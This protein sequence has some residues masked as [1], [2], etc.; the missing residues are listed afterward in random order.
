[1]LDQVHADLQK[2]PNDPNAYTFG[3]IGKHN[4]VIACLPKGKIGTNSAATITTWMVST[5]PSIKFG[6]MVGIGGGIPPKVRLGD[7][8]VSIPVGQFSGVVQWDFGKAKEG[9]FERTGS[10]NNPPNLLL[11]AL[12]K[13]ETKH[14]LTGSKIPEYLKELKEKWPRLIPKYLKSDSLED[15]LCK[16]DYSHIN[17]SRNYG[18]ISDEDDEVETEESCQLCNKA[19]LVKRKPRDMRVHYGLIASGNQVV[20]DSTFRDKLNNDLGGD[21]L[22]VE[23]EAA[24]LMNNFPC[25]VIRGICDYADS[26]KNKA[27]QE[28]AATTAAAFAKE[29][30]SVVPA[31]EV[32]QMPVI[33]KIGHRLEKVL[34]VVNKIDSRQHD[35]EHQTI[36][37]WLTPVNYGPQQSD[38]INRRQLGTGQWLLDSADFQTWLKTERQTLFCPG[39]PGAGKTIL[40]SIVVEDLTTRLGNDES[41][42]IAY[43]YCTFQR[44]GEQKPEELLASL[45]KQL[46]Q[47]RSSLPDKVRS[48]YDEH[49][50]EG[51]RPSF[52]GI[53]KALQSVAGLYSRV[54]IIVDALD[55]CQDRHGCLTS[56]LPAVFSLQAT[57]E[58]NLFATSRDVPEI[59][60][61][62][63]GSMSVEIRATG[64]DVR[65]YLDGRKLT[66]PEF[67]GSSP[68]LQEE[69]QKKLHEEIKTEILK[70]VDGMFLLAQLHLNS[71]IGKKSP[72]AVQDALAKLPTGSEAYNC[73]YEIAMERIER[74]VSDRP[75]VA[76]QV[77]SWITCAKRPLTTT[78][79]QHALAVEIGKP[80]LGE[81]NL[82][83]IE[84]MVSVCAGLVTVDEESGIIRLVHYTTQEYFIKT[85][86]QWFPNVQADIT[87]I[88]VT[89]LS[90]NIFEK[91]FCK[92][93]MEFEE[94][95]RLYPLYDYA[96]HNWGHHAREPLT[97]CQEVINFLECKA[98]VE[99]SSQALVVKRYSAYSGY[100]Q[101]CP[102]QITGLH[103]AAYFGVDKAVNR[104]L[105]GG[106]EPDSEDSY[107]RTPLS[108]A[109]ENGREAVVKLLL[110]KGADTES[111]DDH[112]VRT[113][114]LWAIE[115][116]R[117]AVVK[118][119]LDR[120]ADTESK[121][122]FGRTPLLWAAENGREVVVK[123][124]LDKGAD[125]E[126]KD[127]GY[128][129]TPLLWAAGN[130]H[131]AVVKLLL[132]KGA[133]TES[134]DNN[135][136]TPL[137]WAV[138]SGRKAVIK[139]LLDNGAN[140]ES[141]DNNG[142]T[143]LL[144]AVENGLEAVIKL[145][146]DSGAN[147]ESKDNDGWTPL[148]WAAENSREAVIILLLNKGADVRSKS[149][150]RVQTPLLWATK[151]G[152]EDVVKLL[153]DKGADTES[154]DK[155]GRT[156]LSWAA[157]YGH[158]AIVKLLL[159]KDA[160]TES[161]KKYNDRTPLSNA[162][163]NGHE[164]VVKLLLDK[165]AD[166]ESVDK[167]G[168]TSLSL[169]ARYGHKAIVKLLLNKNADI[170]LSQNRGC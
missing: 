102:G 18:A 108:W 136:R 43:I 89:Y 24:G 131:E 105:L 116:G 157:S 151:N 90:F 34:N 19:K 22:C 15:I 46:S 139:L 8:V 20:K 165:G 112:Y 115:N 121:N 76:K 3:S 122:I 51:T 94:R 111:K 146:L 138:E 69:L 92:T 57:T 162:A 25:I 142:R 164:A 140:I 117:E 118:L 128:G 61:M 45:L 13:L 91:G 28:H 99:A 40:A 63:K 137:S 41:I 152:R 113:P 166:T 93:D 71:L 126:S 37:N 78:E 36:L 16:P 60:V 68:E 23:M 33:K 143:P 130:G 74:Q 144:W 135:G 129:Q 38:Y 52:D 83:T 72:K 168:R 106:H 31:H 124:L 95:L 6:L 161:R 42:G 67:V 81:G 132:N 110:D 85:Q 169:A 10:L 86:G 27:W 109:A 54:F 98:K 114:L 39:I 123:L 103:L 100:S 150:Y 155:I 73:A 125:P 55:E 17:E 97:L 148:S 14:E 120:G 160:N 59:A 107:C 167:I 30:L 149:D 44:Q 153:L 170:E 159:D 47:G 58:T 147:I 49:K 156:S 77:L 154:V 50:Y 80:E 134:K 53:L 32:E 48:L 11:T 65:R 12:T 2:P 141:K 64:D 4:I 101:D 66:M 79:L 75:E 7:V 70:A 29:L 1:M 9:G 56:F 88:C 145:L 21:V 119:L 82:S 133:V 158:E 163:M 35:Q 5:F 62:F 84:Y 26:H 87:A 127:D 104:L 96:T